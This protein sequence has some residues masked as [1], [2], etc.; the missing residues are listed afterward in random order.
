MN[1]VSVSPFSASL[2]IG[3][4]RGYSKDSFTRDDLLKSIR[5]FQD[6]LIKEHDIYLSASL[7]DC[8]IVLRDYAEPHIRIDLIN[9]PRFP[10][11]EKSFKHHTKNL[12]RFLME[13]F[14][15]NR[16]VILYHDEHLMLENSR[17]VGQGIL[18]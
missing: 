9:Y 6:R 10:L 7:S 18:R 15:Q 3:L 2:T 14:E 17:A 4:Q 11:D 8:E 12:A 16:I 1:Q 5:E 13:T